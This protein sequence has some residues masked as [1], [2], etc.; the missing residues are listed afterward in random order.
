MFCGCICREGGSGFGP[1]STIT[2]L[3]GPA[4]GGYAGGIGLPSSSMKNS[5]YPNLDA[6]LL[7]LRIDINAFAA[8]YAGSPCLATFP[9]MW[10]MTPSGNANGCLSGV[11]YRTHFAW[12]NTYRTWPAVRFGSKSD[13]EITT[14]GTPANLS[15][16]LAVSPCS[17]ILGE[18]ATSNERFLALNSSAC[19]SR[20]A[21]LRVRPESL[22]RIA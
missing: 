18:M 9:I 14:N 13:G 3:R 7:V 6:M 19:L 15:S 16:S 5:G 22:S 1:T 8:S 11:V 10:A 12:S 17:K 21:A 2:T 4:V 20:W